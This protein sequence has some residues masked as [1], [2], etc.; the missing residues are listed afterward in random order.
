LWNFYITVA[1]AITGW[2][3]AAGR[4]RLEFLGTP[5]RIVISIGFAAFTGINI[6]SLIWNYNLLN[7]F[8]TDVHSLLRKN[9][10]PDA[11]ETKMV[12]KPLST[13]DIWGGI[14][15]SIIIEAIVGILISLLILFFGRVVAQAKSEKDRGI[16]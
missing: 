15:V 14:P 11:T 4:D 16:C 6:F 9:V 13:L 5:S 2:F 1:L 10:M 3:A 7:S 8:L 12:L